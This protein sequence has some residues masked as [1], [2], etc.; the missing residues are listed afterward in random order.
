MA[1]ILEQF[2]SDD[3]ADKI[4]VAY[5]LKLDVG[6]V[7]NIVIKREN[8]G[9]QHFSSSHKVFKFLKNSFLGH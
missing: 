3:F 7:N 6:G 2:D 5:E 9:C 4:I 1:N 8:D